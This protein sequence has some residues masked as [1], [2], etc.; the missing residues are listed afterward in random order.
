LCYDWSREV[1]QDAKKKPYHRTD[2][3]KMR[4]AQALLGQR[5]TVMV[6]DLPLDN[7]TA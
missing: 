1:Q 2:Q 4:E 3:R 7:A 6:T 5:Q